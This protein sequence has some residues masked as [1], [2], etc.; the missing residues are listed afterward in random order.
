MTMHQCHAFQDSQPDGVCSSA[1]VDAMW[2]AKRH[3]KAVKCDE[4]GQVCNSN[5]LVT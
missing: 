3:F 1:Q 5:T 2:V 4:H